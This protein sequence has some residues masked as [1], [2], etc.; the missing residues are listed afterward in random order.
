[1]LFNYNEGVF[2]SINDRMREIGHVGRDPGIN[3]YMYYDKSLKRGI[4]IF[5]NTSIPY[6]DRQQFE[7]IYDQL[8]QLAPLL[9]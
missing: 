3:T 4:I 9:K 2:W 8:W 5:Y 7:T 6:K 1:M